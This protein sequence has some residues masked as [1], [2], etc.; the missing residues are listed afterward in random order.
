MNKKQEEQFRKKFCIVSKDSEDIW[1]KKSDGKP[2]IDLYLR[3]NIEQFISTLLKEERQE[4]IEMCKKDRKSTFKAS[5]Q[6]I[7]DLPNRL[8]VFMW[9]YGHNQTLDE[10]IEK[11]KTLKLK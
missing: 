5:P 8:R 11:I 7:N 3:W 9:E 10:I 6:E 1:L 4:I 2:V